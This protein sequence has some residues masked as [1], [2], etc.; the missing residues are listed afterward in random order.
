MDKHTLGDIIKDIKNFIELEK[1]SGLDEFMLSSILKIK[2]KESYSDEAFEADKKGDLDKLRQKVEACR[3]C[4]LSQSRR[5]LVF[6]EGNPD[7][8]LMFIGEAPGLEEDIQGKPF[9]G[10]AGILL[11]KIIEAI[12]LKR[13][14]VY[15]ANCLKCRPPQNRNPL[16]SEVFSCR[17]FFLKQIEIIRPEVICCLGKFAMQTL[18]VSDEPI[19]RARGK[20]Y[21]LDGIKVMPTFHPAYLLRNPS[22]KKL[23]WEDMKKIRDYLKTV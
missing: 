15:I 13:K 23:V 2:R 9:V 16:P 18:L 11:T 4:A 14:D 10:K 8:A 20:F 7:A 19:S 6:G 17:E 5:N 21:D 3:E 1:E 22:E 12:S